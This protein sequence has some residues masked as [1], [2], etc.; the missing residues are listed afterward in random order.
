M[1]K[2]K[3]LS[4]FR[5]QIF[6]P[7]AA[8]LIIALFNLIVDPSF[9]KITLGYNNVGNPVLSGYLITILDYG[10]ELAILAIGMTLI[11]IL[12]HIDLSVGY[13]AG[14][15]GAVAAILMTQFG[16]NEWIAILA[17]LV[18]GLCIG[19]YQGT[20]VTRVGVPAFVTTLAGMFIFRGL[21]S[22]ALQETGT[23][24]VPNKGFNA[25]SNGFIPDIPGVD[26]GFHLLTVLIGV[27]L[28]AVLIFTQVKARQNK[29]KYSLAS[30]RQ[31]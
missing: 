20:L 15:S 10:S 14:F 8:L 27:I 31:I 25:L 18:L 17:V 19:L 16:V 24:I 2:S 21:L 22:R 5:H 9:F 12:K 1:K 11:L 7:L 30:R 4:I 23:I 28:V 26:L 29:L 6:I 13:V 3:G